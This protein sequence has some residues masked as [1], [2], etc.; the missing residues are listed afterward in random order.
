MHFGAGTIENIIIS[1]GYLKECIRLARLHLG[2]KR[3]TRKLDF[4]E[5][6]KYCRVM[7][8]KHK[9]TCVG[10]FFFLFG[11]PPSSSQINTWLLSSQVSKLKLSHFSLSTF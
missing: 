7:G 5:G 3:L 2:G 11:G 4:H 6:K 8:K 9:G 10:C 1:R